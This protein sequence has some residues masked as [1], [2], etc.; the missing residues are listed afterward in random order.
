MLSVFIPLRLFHSDPYVT[1]VV[2]HV[3]R[4]VFV[5]TWR[6][7][8]ATTLSITT[9]SITTLSLTTLSLTKLSIGGL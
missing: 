8:G 7:F 9:L 5:E 2:Y 1:F 6:L 4:P 3:K